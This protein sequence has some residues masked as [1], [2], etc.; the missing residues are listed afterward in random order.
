MGL[1]GLHHRLVK[2]FC[3]FVAK[4]FIFKNP[5]NLSN[6]LRFNSER[7]IP[8]SLRNEREL[9]RPKIFRKYGENTFDYFFSKFVNIN[10][11]DYFNESVCLKAIKIYI[12]K[13]LDDVSIHRKKNS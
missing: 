1:F 8:Y 13:N 4:I 9:I 11:I 5:S 3:I 7:K 12:S 2:K 10:L 6:Q